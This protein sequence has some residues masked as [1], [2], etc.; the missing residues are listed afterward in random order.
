[1]DHRGLK[2]AGCK[3]IMLWLLRRRKR[4]RVEGDSMLPLLKSGDEV[5]AKRA[6]TFSVG[7]IVVCRHPI[8]SDITMIKQIE[9]RLEDGHYSVVGLQ[10]TGSSD[11]R[12]FGPVPSK[13][14]AGFLTSIL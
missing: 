12:Q 5:L 1:M 8:R 11:S 10:P 13:L 3:E 6:K 2:P 9:S 4:F 7:D 14:I